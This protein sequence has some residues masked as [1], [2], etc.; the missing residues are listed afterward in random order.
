MTGGLME[1]ATRKAKAERRTDGRRDEAG[2]GY[3]RQIGDRCVLPAA[4]LH[5][6]RQERQRPGSMRAECGNSGH[7][8]GGIGGAWAG[9]VGNRTGHGERPRFVMKRIA[10]NDSV[11]CADELFR[12]LTT[13]DCDAARS[14]CDPGRN[15]KITEHAHRQR[16][17]E[18]SFSL[19]HVG[20][21]APDCPCVGWVLARRLPEP[22]PA[23]SAGRGARRVNKV[24]QLSRAR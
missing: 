12:V 15:V 7:G 1:T 10:R 16:V 22:F 19:A 8:F 14:K 24:P 18:P 17:S 5:L 4:W 3:G 6:Y 2:R 21:A 23:A 20:G 13:F 11:R 9:R